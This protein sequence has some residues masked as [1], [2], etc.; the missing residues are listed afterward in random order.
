MINMISTKKQKSTH[1]YSHISY[2]NDGSSHWINLSSS[3]IQM[4]ENMIRKK[5]ILII[6]S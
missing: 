5:A 3:H 2:T 6:G 4:L 1:F